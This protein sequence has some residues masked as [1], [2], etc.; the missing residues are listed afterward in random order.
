MSAQVRSLAQQYFKENHQGGE[1]ASVK[2][3][4]KTAA[5]APLLT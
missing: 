2:S 1:Q 4:L 5:V 3:T